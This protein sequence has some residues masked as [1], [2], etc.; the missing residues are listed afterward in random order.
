MSHTPA[1]TTPRQRRRHGPHEPKPGAFGRVV[2]RL[3]LEQKLTQ[4]EVTERAGFSRGVVTDYESGGS[5]SPSLEV[6]GEFAVALG[7]TL[8]A[9]LRLVKEEESAEAADA[10]RVTRLELEVK[11]LSSEL[12]A[13][14][15]QFNTSSS[16]KPYAMRTSASRNGARAQKT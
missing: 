15:A 3:R 1:M 8:D 2:R 5:Q 13:F 12:S 7:L 14:V 4:A 11:R 6:A 10:D 9:L 16:S